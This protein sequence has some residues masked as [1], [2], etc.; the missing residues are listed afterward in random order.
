MAVYISF[1]APQAL[2]EITKT[3]TIALYDQTNQHFS[4]KLTLKILNGE[5]KGKSYQLKPIVADNNLNTGSLVSV[6][7][8]SFLP[9]KLILTTDK[10]LFELWFYVFVSTTFATLA[11]CFFVLKDQLKIK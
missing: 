4:K 10:V 2:A 6:R 5:N 7:F 11:L 8:I 1:I 9:N 3:K